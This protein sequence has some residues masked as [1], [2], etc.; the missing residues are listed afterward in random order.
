MAL[1]L[2]LVPIAFEYYLLA[3]DLRMLIFI[4]WTP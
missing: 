2:Y 1:E 4:G 3:H